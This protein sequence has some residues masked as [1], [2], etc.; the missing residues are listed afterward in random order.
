MSNKHVNIKIGESHIVS[1]LTSLWLYRVHDAMLDRVDYFMT[2][3]KTL[4]FR[5]D[6]HAVEF[7]ENKDL[8]HIDNLAVDSFVVAMKAKLAE[9]RAA[10]E[11]GWESI[12]CSDA[13]LKEQLQIQITKGNIVNAANYLMMLHHRG[14]KNLDIAIPS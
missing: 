3:D 14:V 1:K 11:W 9:K 2:S 7:K 8:L 10:G 12:R 5:N 6:R 4:A 13:T